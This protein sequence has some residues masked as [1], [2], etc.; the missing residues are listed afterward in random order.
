METSLKWLGY[1]ITVWVEEYMAVLYGGGRQR[2][3]FHYS[4]SYKF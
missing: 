4:S 3:K 1:G 2:F